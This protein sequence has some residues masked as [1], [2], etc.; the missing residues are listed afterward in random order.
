MDAGRGYF[1]AKGIR[2]RTLLGDDFGDT[3]TSPITWMLLGAIQDLTKQKF[4]PCQGPTTPIKIGKACLESYGLQQ[5][6]MSSRLDFTIIT[7]IT[8]FRMN[9]S[10][11]PLY[12]LPLPLNHLLSY[13]DF[14]LFIPFLPP[15]LPLCPF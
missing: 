2:T 1:T 8:F 15:S 3:S 11:L 12:D 13:I 9:S 14:I 7:T 4:D 6:T 10:I 5:K